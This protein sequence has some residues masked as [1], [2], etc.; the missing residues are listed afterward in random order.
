MNESA[1]PPPLPALKPELFPRRSRLGAALAVCV[2]AACVVFVLRMQ[3]AHGTGG[4][5]ETRPN[6]MLE[7]MARY[8]VGVKELLRSTQ[9]SNAELTQT[10][11][12]DLAG[13]SRTDED[14]LRLLILKGWLMD[15]WPAAA[16]LDAAAA[17]SAGLQA[18]VATLR[19]LKAMHGEVQDEAWKIFRERHGWIADLARAMTADDNART[20]VRQQGMGTAMV[21]IGISMLGMF[22]AA[23]GL[24]VLILGIVRWR[25][26]KLRLLLA[27]R[28]R[29][30][31]GVL[32]EGFAIFLTLFLF[33]P[34]LLRL[35]AVPLPRWAAYGPAVIALIIGMELIMGVVAFALGIYR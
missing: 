5:A 21:L 11:L 28:S 19:Q 12:Q 32:L 17:K 8:A 34:W 22:A 2:I 3:S 15:V 7:M 6:R 25:S 10:G 24:G 4:G 16:D 23:G 27:L 18:D 20:A 31:G 30:E 33:P 14:A 29:A 13:L 35:L 9:Q 26:G 1:E